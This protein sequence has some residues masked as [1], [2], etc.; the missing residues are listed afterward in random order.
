MNANMDEADT[1]RSIYFAPVPLIVLTPNRTIKLLNQPA[2]KLLGLSSSTCI[3]KKI[4]DYVE[5]SSRIVFGSALSD[6]TE[7]LASCE[8]GKADPVTTSITFN[9]PEKALSQHLMVDAT[10]SAWFPTDPVFQP[11]GSSSSNRSTSRHGSTSSKLGASARAPHH[12]LYTIAV[13]PIHPTGLREQ[14]HPYTRSESPN[15]THKRSSIAEY[16]KASCF[17][18]IDL[19][20]IALSKDGNTEIKN[21]SFDDILSKFDFRNEE[22]FLPGAG[23]TLTV[24]DGNFERRL[25]QSDWPIYRCAVLGHSASKRLMGLESSMTGFRV[26]IEITTHAIRDKGGFGD[27]IGGVCIFR[28]MTAEFKK[29]KLDAELQGDLHYRQTVDTMPQLVFHTRPS[30][31]F[32]WYS[33]SFYKYTGATEQLHGAG[34]QTI[35][36]PDD[37]E[38]TGIDFSHALG[39]GTPLETA[40]RLKRHDGVYRWHLAR[41]LPLRDPETGEILKWFGTSTDVDDQVEA[42]SASQRTQS[43]LQSVIHHADI[44]LWAVDRDGII[45]IAEGPGLGLLNLS[46]TTAATNSK[47]TTTTKRASDE[48]TCDNDAGSKLPSVNNM[49]SKEEKSSIIGSSLYEAWQSTDIRE[50]IARAL[51][52]ET[53]VNEMELGGRWFRTSYTPLRAQGRDILPFSL[54][55]TVKADSI[56]TNEGEIIGVVGASMDVTSRKKVEESLQLSIV[57]K[58]RALAAEGAAREASRLKSEFLA[59]M[60]HEVRTPIAGI[61]GLSELLLDEEDLSARQAEFAGTI[62]RSAEGLLTVINDVLDFSKVEIG[63]LEVEQIPFNI[64]VLL[65]DLKRMHMLSTTK[66]GLSFREALSIDFQ[67]NLLGDLGRLKQILTNL[68]SNAIKFTSTGH[69]SLEVTEQYSDA[70]NVTIRFDI[71]D[72]GCG[73][74]KEARSRLF[75]PFSQADS[76]TARRFGGTGLGLSISKNL[77]QLMNGVI[78]LDSVEGQGSHAWFIIPFRKAGAPSPDNDVDD[79][80]HRSIDTNG[81]VNGTGSGHNRKQ[82]VSASLSFGNSGISTSSLSRPKKD[83]W[84]LIAEDNEI[85][86]QI[87]SRNVQKMGFSCNIARDGNVAVK[88]IYN[89]KYDLILMDCQMPDCDGYEATRRIRQSTR[90]DVKSLPIIALTASAI[91]GDRERALD[92]GM[93][94]Y[95]SKPVKRADLENTLCKW[96]FDDNVR[97]ALNR[98]LLVEPS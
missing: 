75:K 98:F 33:P 1:L 93:V 90:D 34:W 68:I 83:I 80:N 18:C 42:L 81:N 27:H 95:L 62:Q 61:I 54:H 59:N 24:Y 3:G 94:D 5:A 97:Q 21:K 12:A 85:N 15:S 66:K 6:A 60:S 51:E 65:K 78:G 23:Q 9:T 16:I 17:D 91:T 20:V 31:F 64:V 4:N 89:Q 55:N 69:I 73:I 79:N 30:G 70:N 53:V 50:T 48:A 56:K 76:T 84:I 92:A 29:Q 71:R 86:A 40:S 45:T 74:Q 46:T 19:G 96:L 14:A 11:E 8:L 39:T 67:G 88:E 2:E 26:T 37:L 87:A 72:T 43:Q 58:T 7:S 49:Q 38:Q 41:A 57:E 32:D 28:D 77:V 13:M 52:G 82:S 10:I 35:V 47:N 25:E 63:K 22:E 36:H 44:T